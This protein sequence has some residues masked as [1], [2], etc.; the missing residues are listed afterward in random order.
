MR[1]TGKK[2]IRDRER[3][4]TRERGKQEAREDTHLIYKI[5]FT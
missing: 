2:Q 1:E 4:A 5:K 3:R